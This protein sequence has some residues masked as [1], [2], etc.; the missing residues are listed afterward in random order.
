MTVRPLYIVRC[1]AE[2]CRTAYTGTLLAS[3]RLTLEAAWVAGWARHAFTSSDYCPD[4]AHLAR[5]RQ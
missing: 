2:N 3:S 1:D 4:H 5:G